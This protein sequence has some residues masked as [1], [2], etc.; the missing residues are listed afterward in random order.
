MENMKEI[1]RVAVLGSGVMGGAIA[2]HLA[3]CGIPTLMLDITPP[4]LSD[5][6]KQKK[7]KRN[8]FAANSKAALLK[9]KPSPLYLKSN[10]D[11]IQIGNFDDDFSK[12][13]ECDWI[14][15]VVKE[16]IQV[17]KAVFE[18]IRI[19]RAKGSIVSTN[20]SGIPIASME[21]SMDEEMRSCFLGTHF[22][23]P[24]RYLKLLEIVPGS[25]T[26]PE[27]IET[28]AAFGE[29]ILG[30]GVVHAKDTP[31]FIA[32]RILTF[33]MSYIMREMTKPEFAFTFEDVDALTGPIIGHASSATF[34]TADLV[35]MD[36][37]VHVIENVREGCP[38]DER[39][40][41]LE[42]P[43]WLGKMLEKGYYGAKSGSGFFKKTDRRDEKGKPEI[44]SLDINAMEYVT[45]NKTSFDS[46]EAAKHVKSLDEKV[47]IMHAGT[48][49]A[50]TFLWN[51]FAN[52]AVYAANRIPEIAD[53][54]LNIDNAL[55][56]GFAWEQGL[57]ETW[58][59]L[60]FTQVCDR[61]QADGLTLPPIVE[62]MKAA[63][64]D[65]FYKIQDGRRCFF[66]LQTKSYKPL[67]SVGNAIILDEIRP[68][69]EFKRNGDASLID[70]GDGVL[71]CE[72][73]C[74]MNVVDKDIIEM[75]HAGI[76][77]VNE[78]K[79]DG[80]VLANQAPHFSAGANLML[81]LMNINEQNW[82]AIDNIIR[83]FQAANMAMRFCRGPVVTAP[84]HYTFG[85][86]LEMIQHGAKAVIAGETYGGLVEVGVGLIPGGGGCK[87]MLRRALA[88]VPSGVPEPSPYPYVRRAFESIATAKVSTSGPEL[89]EL[90][91]LAETDVVHVNW[92][93]QTQRA[94]DVC[95]GMVIA[96]YRPP[97]PARLIALGEPMR[98]AFRAGV[99]NLT[100]SGW[101]SKH[102]A[103]IAEKVAHILTGGNRLPGTPITEQDVLDLE[104]EAFLSLCGITESQERLKHMLLNNKPLRN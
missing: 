54:I 11:L 75:I 86:G 89:I 56:W 2:A 84:H 102:D 81:F 23:N 55:K 87:E 14:C 29:N 48:D 53:D 100:E 32:N 13:A 27:V 62:T 19:H 38:N 59:V 40:D 31:N 60:G 42:P 3:N 73:H 70:L 33:M 92:D 43:E 65:A 94:K 74:K 39:R 99:Y 34:R 52:S 44:L 91:Y 58:D 96:G 22:F 1:K 6:D 71:C 36:T 104:R 24:P 49:K 93:Q 4:N 66:D 41:I 64:A 50:S 18:K 8:T 88:Y 98:A 20:T 12:I 10:I 103:L 97:L 57:F 78:G 69:R 21:A 85:G 37:F 82:D 68:T 67:L 17:K 76:D 77:A 90:G 95:R 46:L 79:F 72:F 9:T 15:E 5:A 83:G 47:R 28:I 61:M 63:G 30:K 25:A 7:A 51:V 45:Q 101:A 16:D 80:M 35:G 26:S